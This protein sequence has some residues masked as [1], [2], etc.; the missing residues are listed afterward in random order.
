MPQSFASL[1]CHIIFSTKNRAPLISPD[2][3]PRLF[4][5]LGGIARNHGCRLV[6]AGG[7]PDHVHLACTLPVTLS[8]ADFVGKIKG[9][10]SHFMNHADHGL[11]LERSFDWQ[12]GYGALTF[13]KRDL[14]RIVAYIAHQKEHHRNGTRSPKMERWGGEG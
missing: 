13:A 11:A 9:A 14:A 8:I 2:L 12:P 6:A 4:E 10:S 3:Q 1:H 5:Y 7:M